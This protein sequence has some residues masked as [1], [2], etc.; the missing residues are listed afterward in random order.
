M[1]KKCIKNKNMKYENM[2]I[3]KYKNMKIFKYACR[4]I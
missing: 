3:Q 1:Y 2:K 4:K